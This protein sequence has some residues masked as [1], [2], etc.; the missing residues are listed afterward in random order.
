MKRILLLGVLLSAYTGY[1]QIRVGFENNSQ[2]YVDD[3]K[4]KIEPE[5]AKERFRTNSYLKLD[6]D[7]KKWS[8]GAQVEG[9]EP[10]ALLNYSPDYK[11]VDIGT[12]YARYNDYESG[13]DIT[14]GHFYD[15]FGSG[16]LFRSW[17]DRQ[18]GIN[19]SVFG[20]N[21]KYAISEDIGITA[22]GGKQRIGMGFDLS[23]SY[24]FGA[25]LNFDVGSMLK[26]ENMD[27]G[28]G[29]S[30]LGRLEEESDYNKG[31]DELTNAMSFRLNLSQGGFYGDLEYV[32]KQEDALVELGR[33]YP[34]VKQAGNALLLNA[35]YSKKGMAINMNL[36]RMENMAFYSQREFNGDIYMKGVVNYIPALTK[37]YD[38]SLQNIYVYQAQPNFDLNMQRKLGEIGGQFDFFYE[39]PK[40]ST[41]GGEY[42]TNIVANGSYWAGIKSKIKKDKTG[43]NSD[44]LDFGEK[45]Y[46]DFGLE[47]R[48][49]WS[50]DWSSI[51][52]F[53]N[54]YYNSPYLNGEFEVV[55]AN[56][57]S[58][59]STYQFLGNKSVRLELQHLWADA[60]KKNWV[61]G[62][63]EFAAN[64]NWSFYASD[65]YNYGNDNEDD[66]IHYYNVGASFTKGTTRV[67]AGYGRQRGGLLCVGGVCRMVSE[68]AGLTL[69]ITTSF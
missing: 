57:V 35:G 29:V 24:L 38:Y 54:Q 28:A 26:F 10:K 17:E 47:V 3:K 61:G 43:V 16:L 25:D 58:A 5:E 18:L 2:W 32:Y 1:S 62:T 13:L 40:G 60:D 69:G 55:Q 59:E 6:Y 50:K 20:L 12:I 49:K 64:S 36:R 11:G 39:F 27:L 30:Y 34:K 66:R 45:Y 21:V 15:Q 46:H 23:D 51:F 37:Q 53:L 19:N 42:G 41:F 33:L 48:K 9:Y 56:I 31:L 22:L 65:M 4:V 63:V 68:A 8:F 67:S 7:Y 44:F 14:A 52:M